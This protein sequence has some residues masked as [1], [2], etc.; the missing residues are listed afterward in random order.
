M[1]N[2][3]HI[4]NKKRIARVLLA[5]AVV[6]LFCGAFCGAAGAFSPGSYDTAKELVDAINNSSIAISGTTDTADD[7]VILMGDLILDK[8]GKNQELNFGNH[9]TVSGAKK[10]YLDLNGHVLKQTKSVGVI[11]IWGNTELIIKDGNP[12]EEHKFTVGSDGLWILDESA[13]SNYKVVNGGVITGGSAGEGG[14]ILIV[15]AASRF[16]LESGNIVGNKGTNSRGYSGGGVS[17]YSENSGGTFIMNG[18]TI[19]GNVTINGWDGGGVCV[20]PGDNFTMTGGKI[21]NNRSSDKGGGVNVLGTFN[22]SGGSIDSNRSN[23]HGG[24]VAVRTGGS[25][26]MSGNAKI[27]NNITGAGCNGGG[28]WV[29]KNSTFTLT[30]GEISGNE[31]K[32]NGGGV[33][34]SSYTCTISME[35]ST[36]VIRNN[37]AV[38]GGGIMTY[39][40]FNI[41]GTPDGSPEISGNRATGTGDNGT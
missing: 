8:Q 19:Q 35:N 2:E 20:C 33:Y 3:N 16:T 34:I 38:S 21:A 1:K 27:T 29:E 25:F 15:D 6:L 14:G 31:A 22:M 12:N 36:A 11:Q 23:G 4:M 41:S 17:T 40:G 39:C 5:A 7:T 10:I 13:L 30:G 18:G 32:N 9:G 37:T 24:G 26:T 28:V